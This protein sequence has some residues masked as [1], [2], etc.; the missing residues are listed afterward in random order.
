MKLN[1]LKQYFNENVGPVFVTP[2]DQLLFRYKKM[3]G[4]LGIVRPYSG[5]S[6]LKVDWSLDKRWNVLD[7]LQKTMPEESLLPAEL[8]FLD[9]G[10]DIPQSA[11]ERLLGWDWTPQELGDV[12]CISDA[13]LREYQATYPMLGSQYTKLKCQIGVVVEKCTVDADY[14][15]VT[16]TRERESY[17]QNVPTE[18]LVKLP[19]SFRPTHVKKKAPTVIAK[20]KPLY[21]VG[22][23]VRVGSSVDDETFMG[24]MG[25]VEK[26]H[27][28]DPAGYKKTYDWEYTVNFNLLPNRCLSLCEDEDAVAMTSLTRLAER[29]LSKWD[30]KESD[31]PYFGLYRAH[32]NRDKVWVPHKQRLGKVMVVS[33]PR[34]STEEGMSIKVEMDGA[35]SRLEMSC[36][37]VDYK[38]DADVLAGVL[39]DSFITL[40]VEQDD[41]NPNTPKQQYVYLYLFEYAK[42]VGKHVQYRILL[43]SLL[44]R[45]STQKKFVRALIGNKLTHPWQVIRY[46]KMKSLGYFYEL[47]EAESYL[48]TVS[49]FVHAE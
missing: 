24:L 39:R 43:G 20:S 3:N 5:A 32:A 49:E 29:H 23:T 2:S 7:A 13:R 41:A 21:S 17:V 37:D 9:L 34:K 46:L 14:I 12:V 33:S 4:M 15:M 35:L 18:L 1:T 16:F 30:E 36:R 40:G 42:D 11:D 44:R 22:Q 19:E 26:T 45:K 31:K 28:V 25:I 27:E 6:G 47:F 38:W 10:Q 48:N 8:D